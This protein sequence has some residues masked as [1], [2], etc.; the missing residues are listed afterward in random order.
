MKIVTAG[1][2]RHQNR[3]L[4]AQRRRGKAQEFLWEFPGG[5]LEPGETLEEC[6]K[7]ELFEE[8]RLDVEVGDFFMDSQF[9]YES[10]SILLKVFWANCMNEDISY[11][12]SHEQVK[13]VEPHE[14]SSY[15]FAPADRPVIR[16]LLEQIA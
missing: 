4:I 8:M 11:L 1:I 7:R 2:V 3:I 6:L 15:D 10:G 14:L 5:K 16:A 9:D 13:W 12:D